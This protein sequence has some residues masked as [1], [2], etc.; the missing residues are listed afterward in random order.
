MSQSAL[1]ARSTSA[2]SRRLTCLVAVHIAIPAASLLA[3]GRPSSNPTAAGSGV[4]ASYM[5]VE[6]IRKILTASIG[7]RLQIAFVDGVTQSVEIGSVDD[8]GFLHSGLEEG[9]DPRD[10]WTRFES[11]RSIQEDP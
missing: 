2:I 7:R 10:F 11:V 5:D 8:E 3:C 6:E 1:S 9:G 4:Y